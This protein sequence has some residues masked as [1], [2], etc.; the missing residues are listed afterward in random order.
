MLVP[1]PVQYKST[2]ISDTTQIVIILKI[3]YKQP[4]LRA[5]CTSTLSN[6]L[7]APCSYWKQTR[8]H[9]YFKLFKWEANQNQ[10]R[11]MLK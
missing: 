3:I 5:F 2:S 7:S 4:S 11:A 8:R 6:N 1:P 9:E 10:S